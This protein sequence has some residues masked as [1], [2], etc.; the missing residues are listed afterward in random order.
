MWSSKDEGDD[1]MYVVRVGALQ[2]IRNTEINWGVY[3]TFHVCFS[4]RSLPFKK[5]TLPGQIRIYD[6]T[7]GR[8][9]GCLLA[10]VRFSEFV[11]SLF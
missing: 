9:V 6:L 3:T 5:K 11:H 2:T 8:Q 10:E 4:G 7:K 1:D